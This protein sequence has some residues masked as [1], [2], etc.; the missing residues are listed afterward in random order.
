ME[1]YICK[2]CNKIFNKKHHLISHTNKKNPCK[3]QL[4]NSSELLR[5]PPICSDSEINNNKDFEASDIKNIYK[6]NKCNLI[7][8]KKFNLERHLNGRCICKKI[9][10]NNQVNIDE[11]DIDDKTKMILSL[12][13]NQNKKK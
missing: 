2:N 11:L 6:C 4:L 8:K 12:L 1:K 13:L 3:Q 9:K 5:T 10:E 7:F